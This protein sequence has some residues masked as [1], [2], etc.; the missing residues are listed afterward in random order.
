MPIERSTDDL[1]ADLSSRAWELRRDACEDLGQ[2]GEKIAVA[3]I[4]NLLKDS[5]GAVRY[6]AVQS[7]GRI[8]GDE[9]VQPLLDCLADEGF[10]DHAPVLE[11]IGNMGRA[12]AIPYLIKF[13]RDP[14]PMMRGIANTSLM[15]TTGQVLGF[16]ATAPEEEREMAI[17][18]WEAWWE[19]TDGNF[20]PLAA[21]L[22]K[23]KKKKPKKK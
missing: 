8:G 2:R 16:K 14:D 22:K 5:V 21:R 1:I 7:L 6:A 20:V 4:V 10:G 11:A 23:K 9:I 12:E 19:S 13:L 3:Y 18:K 15:V 17:M